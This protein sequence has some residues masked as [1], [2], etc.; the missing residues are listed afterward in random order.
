MQQSQKGMY[1]DQYNRLV[2]EFKTIFTII[3]I[4]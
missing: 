2:S 3:S 4:I 1:A